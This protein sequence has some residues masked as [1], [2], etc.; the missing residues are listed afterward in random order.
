MEL[1]LPSREIQRDGVVETREFG[2]R[3]DAISFKLMADNLYTD[4]ILAVLREY[5]CNARDAMIAAGRGDEPITVHLPNAFEP[6]FSVSDNGIG[7][8]PEDCLGLFSTYFDSTK[9]AD[10]SVTGCFG[11]GSKSA[12][13]Y[14]D[15][16]T[17]TS[18]W[19]GF[20][21][22]F[23][24]VIGENGIP[25]IS[26]V[27]D[28]IAT[29]QPNGV[30]ITVPVQERD[31]HD[32]AQKASRVY[33]RFT[34]VPNVTGNASY[35]I[36]PMD[37]W[38][39]GD[40]NSWALH[41]TNDY[42]GRGNPHAIQGGVTY[43][44]EPNSLSNVDEAVR[45][46][47][48]LPIDIWFD[49]GS[50]SVQ[51]SREGLSYDEKTQAAIKAKLG[52][53]AN[54]IPSKFQHEFDNCKTL[55]EARVLWHDVLNNK[56]NL[57]SSLKNILANPTTGIKFA[58]S[59]ISGDFRLKPSTDPLLSGLQLIRFRRG[60]HGNRGRVYEQEYGN[61]GWKFTPNSNT[62][63]VYD[64]LG[65]GSH[66]RI[67]HALENYD[68]NS[69]RVPNIVILFKASDIETLRVISKSIGDAPIIP[70]SIFSKRPKEVTQN[71]R[72]Y[73]K[74]L[75][76]VG[77]RHDARDSW[78]PTNLDL[79]EGGLYVTINRYR[80]HD[81]EQ[82]VEDFDAIIRLM[83]SLE[84]IDN[85]TPIYGIRKGLVKD[86]PDD[87]EWVDV[88]DCVRKKVKNDIVGMNVVELLAQRESVNSLKYGFPLEGYGREIVNFPMSENSEF[89]SF[90]VDY[91][92]AKERNSDSSKIDNIENLAR[93][94]SVKI[95]SAKSTINFDER[96]QNVINTY[97]MLRF[98]DRYDLNRSNDTLKTMIDYINQIDG[99][100]A[101]EMKNDT[102]K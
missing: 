25:T 21:Y 59:D 77:S 61:N 1:T 42:Y 68:A 99:Y 47:L 31:F 51:T 91:N 62:L 22:M 93:K 43:P 41:R 9:R 71:V 97:P 79:K 37:Y 14:T 76:W 101:S 67:V 39:T 35:K 69:F 6:Y 34:P 7:L 33:R 55:W 10:N 54:Q 94:L 18:R 49:T 36:E 52:E 87:S 81:G 65:H 63:F 23:Q 40:D 17:V 75:R 95:E 29:D 84:Y 8:S 72:Q 38:L 46:V 2:F 45:M 70:A 5:G 86:L 32:F 13:A 90:V 24:C 4:K 102:G 83:V 78:T 73:A 53:I 11:L 26:Q 100:V 82:Q 60:E 64:D 57:P 27:G 12:F 98:V 85:D 48:Q 96:W 58:G 92:T 80:V 50:L 28:P 74:V 88:F 56:S 16:F 89:Y 19:N 66:S 15:S 3:L 30:T 20:M 44:I